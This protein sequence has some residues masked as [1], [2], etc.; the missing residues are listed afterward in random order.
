VEYELVKALSRWSPVR[1]FAEKTARGETPYDLTPLLAALEPEMQRPWRE[2]V[3]AAQLL[4]ELP[5]STLERQRAAGALRAIA[6][7]CRLR[8][9]PKGR[10]RRWQERTAQ[11]SLMVTAGLLSV[12]LPSLSADADLLF[13]ICGYFSVSMLV[14][15]PLVWPFS[16]IVEDIRFCR[17]RATAIH[18]LAR[19]HNPELVGSSVHAL[20]N[21]RAMPL[22]AGSSRVRQAAT[23]TLP[24]M[25]ARLMPEHYGHLDSQLVPQMCR[26]LHYGDETL[27]LALLQALEKVGGGRAV[28]SVEALTGNGFTA[29]LRV[30]PA[31]RAEALRVLPV[32]VARR[33]QENAAKVL[34]R[35]SDMGTTA[36]D[37]LLRPVAGI[38]DDSP[39]MLL[40]AGLQQK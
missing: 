25:L 30:T 38:S 11:L 8:P 14:L 22:S 39:Q 20:L 24:E 4:V 40:R 36:P 23:E 3:V 6:A 29:T 15:L 13:R 21:A 35:A 5:L 19:L 10:N 28:S 32:L 27:T 37:L 7:E 33:E 12:S 2:Q 34:L 1:R 26:A 31:V 18:T 17:V 9:N 16:E